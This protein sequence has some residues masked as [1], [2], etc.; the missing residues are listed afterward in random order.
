M[1]LIVGIDPGLPVTIGVINAET[2]APVAYYEGEQ[3][4]T[5]HHVAKQKAA[6]W[7]N[8]PIL[9]TTLLEDCMQQQS[10]QCVVIERVGPMPTDG[11]VTACLFTG[12][13]YLCMG[14]CAGLGVPIERP[15]P[16]Q[17]KKAMKLSG[18]GE[19]LKEL[20]RRKAISLWPKQAKWF[21]F[22]KH[23][24]RAEAL[25]LAEWGRRTL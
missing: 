9:I 8:N 10:I 7:E 15:T 2:G 11:L 19:D 5:Q 16:P 17:W 24:N 12:S 18:N 4:A 14:I 22:K 6:R 20:S 3:V 25:L 21:N 23:H 1:G 13:M